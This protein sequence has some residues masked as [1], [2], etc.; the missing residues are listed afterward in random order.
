MSEY[1]FSGEACRCDRRLNLVLQHYLQSNTGAVKDVNLRLFDGFRYAASWTAKDS[2]GFICPFRKG[3]IRQ[4]RI[5]TLSFALA[6]YARELM[7]RG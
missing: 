2:A 5:L 6:E 7:I 4:R 1:C 3:K